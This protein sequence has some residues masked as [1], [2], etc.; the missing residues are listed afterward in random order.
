M[1]CEYTYFK[2]NW[3]QVSFFSLNIVASNNFVASKLD[4]W[5]EALKN[6]LEIPTLPKLFVL[7]FPFQ[8]YFIS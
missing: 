8:I 5:H 4:H 2:N 1:S 6:Y 3:A 7:L